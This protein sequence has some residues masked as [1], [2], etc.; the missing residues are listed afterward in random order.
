MTVKVITFGSLTEI[1]DKE[2]MA[3]ATDTNTLMS[4]LIEKNG[5]LNKRKLIL[6]V[7]NTIVRENTVLNEHDVVAIMPPYSGG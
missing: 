5:G 2:F 1:M 3:Q 4:S 7:N 6:A